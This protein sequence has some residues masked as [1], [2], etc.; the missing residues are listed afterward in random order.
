MFHF[1]VPAIPLTIAAALFFKR[2]SLAY[3]FPILLILIDVF[4]IQP[5]LVYFFTGAGLILTVFLTRRLKGFWGLSFWALA[6]YTSMAIFIH[7]LVS[8][9]GVWILA[10]C[11]AESSPLYPYTLAGLLQCYRAALPYSAIQFL[12][13]I[14]LAILLIKGLS[15]LAKLKADVRLWRLKNVAQTRNES[16]R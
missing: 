1:F 2:N 3:S 5:S 8:N 9:F 13:D 4:L 6:A 7:E 14:P 10:G 11:T 12:R 15:L 16:P